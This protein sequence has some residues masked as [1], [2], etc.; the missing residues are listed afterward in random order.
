MS[1]LFASGGLGS[2]CVNLSGSS[3]GAALV[4]PGPGER[5]PLPT[6]AAH[7]DRCRW[8]SSIKNMNFNHVA[9]FCFVLGVQGPAEEE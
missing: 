8:S 9:W 2:F 6:P 3:L 1:F 5:S 7:A 4:V